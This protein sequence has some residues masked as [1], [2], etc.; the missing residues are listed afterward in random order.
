MEAILNRFEHG[1]FAPYGAMLLRITL[2]VMW[3][4]H[5]LF[6]L[7]VFGVAGLAAWLPSAGFPS[8]TAAP[9][10]GAELLAGA[11]ILAGVYG[12]F[13]SVVM[14]PVLIG[15]TTVHVANGWVFSNAGGGWEYPVF[16]IVASIVHATQRD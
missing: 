11:L 3:L 5:G 10:I 1:D 8:W 2:G 7:M 6:K 16:L 4:A 13:V 14:L 15:A 9:L 12:R